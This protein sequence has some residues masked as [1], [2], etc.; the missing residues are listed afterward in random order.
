M[1]GE[2]SED[3]TLDAD[4]DTDDLVLAHDFTFLK[5]FFASDGG[6]SFRISIRVR[7]RALITNFL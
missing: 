5:K 4:A 7:G 6:N 2:K 3:E 1:P